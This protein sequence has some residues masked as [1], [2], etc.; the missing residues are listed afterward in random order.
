MHIQC[1]IRKNL[2]NGF[3]HHCNKADVKIVDLYLISENLVISIVSNCD[4]IQI[5]F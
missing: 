3:F 5:P 2:L 4:I 1:Q